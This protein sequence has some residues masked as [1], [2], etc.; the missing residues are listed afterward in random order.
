MTWN[1]PVTIR[2]DLRRLHE[3]GRASDTSREIGYSSITQ[4]EGSLDLIASDGSLAAVYG[5][6]PDGRFGVSLIHKGALRFIPDLVTDL[7]AEDVALSGRISGLGDRMVSAEGRLD[8]HDATLSSHN[9][10]IN[11]AQS[12]ADDAHG[13]AATAQARA[14]DAH[15]DAATAQSRADSA[16]SR[17][18]TGISDAATAQSRADDAY[19]LASGAATSGQLSAL[20]STVADIGNKQASIEQWLID[21][22]GYPMPMN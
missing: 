5:D 21:N 13:D 1:G 3:S 11:S 2:D 20:A 22:L 6:Q 15:G 7:E 12:R 4:G 17:A 8:G 18:G 19:A 9:S 10:R 16:Y 14:D